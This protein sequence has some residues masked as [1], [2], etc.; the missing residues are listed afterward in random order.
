MNMNFSVRKMNLEEWLQ[1][2]IL[3]HLFF[4]PLSISPAQFFLSIAVTGGFV[5]LARVHRFREFSS[6]AFFL[7]VFLFMLMIILSYFWSV[8]PSITAGKFHRMLYYLGLFMTG[9]LLKPDSRGLRTAVWMFIAGAAAQAVWDLVRVPVLV[10]RFGVNLYDTGNMRDPQM[11]L[12]ALCLLMAMLLF[13]RAQRRPGPLFYAALLLNAAGLVIHFKR[14]VWISFFI[15]LF[16][17]VL[18]TRRWKVLLAAALVAGSLVFVPQVQQRL[19]G[20]KDEFRTGQGGRMALWT[21]VAPAL[22]SEHPL[23]M[24]YCATR[25]EDFTPHTAYV[26]PKLTHVHNNILQMI[27]ELGWLGLAV[28]ILWMGVALVSYVRLLR[29]PALDASGDRWAAAGGLA[30]LAGLLLNGMVEY[31][32]GDS[33]ILMVYCFLMGVAILLQRRIRGISAV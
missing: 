2:L 27:L 26:Q 6:N 19:S 29:D 11:Y 1:A 17:L 16:L 25:N 28:W 32:F 5:F 33:E 12:V 30:A 21:D 20:L 13:R 4:I 22:I 10:M 14:G 31:N 18:M 3:L 9:L 8:R 23:G 15:A 24:G 7:P